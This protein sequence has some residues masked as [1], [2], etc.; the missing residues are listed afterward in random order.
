[1][2]CSIVYCISLVGFMIINQWTRVMKGLVSYFKSSGIITT[3]K[4]HVNVEHGLIA[5]KF[6]DEVNNN[7]K[8]RME[9]KI[10]KKMPKKFG[11]AIFNFL[12]FVDSFKKDNVNKKIILTRFDYSCQKSSTL[13]FPKNISLKHMIV[14]NCELCVMFPSQKNIFSISI[15]EPNWK[16]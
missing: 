1:M 15:I 7:T 4:K 3:L 9:K 13:L 11:S 14:R 2:M 5:K 16:K 12:G 8:T 10:V 6:E